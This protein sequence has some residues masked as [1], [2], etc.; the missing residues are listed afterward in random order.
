MANR[1]EPQGSAA[2]APREYRSAYFVWLC[3]MFPTILNT[4]T[5]GQARDSYSAAS[6][7]G[8]AS[9]GTGSPC[10]SSKRNPRARKRGRLAGAL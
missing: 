9:T 8:S 4:I 1:T 10:D 2:S 6:A 3:R 5:G 7:R